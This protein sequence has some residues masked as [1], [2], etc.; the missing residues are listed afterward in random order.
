MVYHQGKK[1]FAKQKAKG[2]AKEGASDDGQGDKGAN[3]KSVFKKV[4]T[5]ISALNWPWL[6]MN[7]KWST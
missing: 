7:R 3:M 5:P 1:A 4:R 6:R 2:K